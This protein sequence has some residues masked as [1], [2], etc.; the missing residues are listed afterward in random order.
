[1]FSKRNFQLLESMP[2]EQR[3]MLE[4]AILSG[5]IDANSPAIK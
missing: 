1:M 2:A 3:K 4:A 5:E